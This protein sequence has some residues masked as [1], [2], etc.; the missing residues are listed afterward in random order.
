MTCHIFMPP[1]LI[2]LLAIGLANHVFNFT[3][4]ANQLEAEHPGVFGPNG[5]NSRAFSMTNI[6]WK[7]GMLLGPLISG[8]LTES[9]GYYYMNLIFGKFIP[10]QFSRM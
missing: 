8:A 10:A 2:T 1:S 3:D 9:V 7:S 6:S 5:G 4:G